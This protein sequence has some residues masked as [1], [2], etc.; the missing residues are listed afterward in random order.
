[1]D[2]VQAEDLTPITWENFNNAQ[3][4]KT[5]S[6]ETQMTYKGSS[7][8]NTVFED[9]IIFS[10][11]AS[12]TYGTSNGW[13]GLRIGVNANDQ[14]FVQ[15]DNY[16]ASGDNPSPYAASTFEL[17][18]LINKQIT[19]RIEMRNVT[20][21]TA[22]INVYVNGHAAGGTISITRAEGMGTLGT[23]VAF[24]VGNSNP[25]TIPEK[26]L[27]E[28]TWTDFNGAVYNKTYSGE[29][30]MTYKG[31]SLNHTAFEGDIIFSSGASMTYGTS[32]G[33]HGLR[34]GVNADDQLFVQAD[35][36]H[37]SGDNPSPYAAST[38]ELD[39]LINARITLRIEMRNVTADT[40]N[41]NVYVNG[42]AAG[43]TISI[44]RAEG[45]GT[46][47][48][49]VAFC[50]GNSNPV[51][52]PEKPLKEITW[53]DF[54]GAVYNKTYSGETQMTYKGTSL[55][56]TAFEGDIIFSSGAS[57]TYG[58]SN[59]WHGLRIGVNENDQL[60][61]QADNYFA[62]GNNP[63]PYA[64]STFELSTLTDTR[65]TLRIE[66]R[67]VTADTANINVYV[68]G[69][70]A[71]GTIS[72]TKAEGAGGIGNVL[73]FCVGNTKPVTIP[74]KALTEITWKD[75]TGTVYGET[76][77]SERQFQYKKDSLDNTAFEGDIVFS[78][79]SSLTYGTANG[80][81]GLRI[82]VNADDQ[83]FV[84]SDN[85]H[86]S[87]DNP[88]PYSA[89]V[90]EL[91]TLTDAR[92][93]LRVEMRN[94]TET[95][96]D[97]N[98][99]VN[100][101]PAGGRI[102]ITKAEGAG[103]IGNVLAFCV[104]DTKPVTILKDEAVPTG[105]T[106][107]SWE[108]F[109]FTG[110]QTYST[111]TERKAL[112]L[113]NLNDTLFDGDVQMNA[114]AQLVYGGTSASW[115]AGI[116]FLP[117]NDGTLTIKVERSTTQPAITTFNPKHYGL[118]NFATDRFNLKIAM[119]DGDYTNAAAY[120]SVVRIWV[121]GQILGDAFTFTSNGADSL[122]TTLHMSMTSIAITPYSS[123]T[124]APTG[125][126]EISFKDWKADI[127]VD[128]KMLN[129]EISEAHPKVNSFLGTTL[130]E[131][132]NLSGTETSATTHV[133]CY[134]GNGTNSWLGTRIQLSG[135]NMVIS[136][137]D[138]GISFTIDPQKAGV[139]N[140]FANTEF[141]WRIDTVQLGK[142]VLL[143]MSFNGV[144]YNK[145]PFV[146]Y[147]FADTISN[148]IEYN[149]YGGGTADQCANYYVVL[150]ASTKTLP[151]LY[152]DLT[153][154]VYTI[155]EYQ[156]VTFYEKNASGEWVAA[157]KPATLTTTGNYKLEFND[158]V[159]EYTQEI[160]CYYYQTDVSAATLVRSLK[161]NQ[162]SMTRYEEYGE[163]Y[164]T[165][166][167]DTNYDGKVDTNDIN[168]IRDMLLETYQAEENV[169]KISGF[170]SP[171]ASIIADKTYEIIKETGVN[172]IIE[173]D[174]YYS[175]DALE[176]YR[177]YQELTY[178]QKYGLTV[179]VKD[180][181]LDEIG[182]NGGTATVKTV[183]DAIVNYK[184]YQSFAGLFIYD[185]PKATDYPNVGIWK[186]HNEVGNYSSV[187]KAI[188][189]AGYEGWSNA[190]GGDADLLYDGRNSQAGCY[191]RYGYFN[192][193]NNMV[194]SYDLDFMSFTCYP[195]TVEGSGVK[196]NEEIELFFINL[197]MAK[198][199]ADDKSI[200]LRAFVQNTASNEAN[201]N[202]QFSE[203]QLKWQ[204][205]I[206]LAFGAKALEYFP[207][208]QASGLKTYEDGSCAS[209]V[210]DKDGNV[211]KFA[212]WT[213][214]AN[215]QAAAVDDILLH[216]TNVGFM[217]TGGASTDVAI[218]NIESVNMR[219]GWFASEEIT[220]NIVSQYEGASVA[221]S[222][223]E[224]GAFTGCF[225]IESGEY[226]G[227]NAMYIVNF[228]DKG[229]N[230]VTV[231]LGDTVTST[232]IYQGVEAEHTGTFDMT[233][234]AGEAVLVVY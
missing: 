211:T 68:N 160:A 125:L 64:A 41:V 158:G 20:A 111:H 165:R 137:L 104:G 192:Y 176:R 183:Q 115:A 220:N 56:H 9:D 156:A 136:C 212:E 42:H 109:G 79:G 3:Y 201:L 18:K 161:M 186:G 162:T 22:S 55:N 101:Y 81:H 206:N 57:M 24:C 10:S 210:V 234:A 77:T 49:V 108:E 233:L 58:T 74:E 86:A 11:G 190:F 71:G 171:T 180:K 151:V 121:N 175:N 48:T 95:T 185:E 182:A 110:G 82:G 204:A 90:F 124:T 169:M 223:A 127:E 140:S 166:L 188:A 92:I 231:T 102:S 145:A 194:D 16:H 91:S 187:A 222:N 33:W 132:V 230:T 30:Q 170:F 5:Y 228:S 149:S 122:G 52:I 76:Y 196:N 209:G 177:I 202:T 50:V 173:S 172:H 17:D 207:L 120:T 85:Y 135:K 27:K 89:S 216:A 155:P 51:T 37:A 146:L 226:A 224:Y 69:H 119:T 53:T 116:H 195:F 118:T 35:N 87:G 174:V 40:A 78:A 200:E 159:S 128:G 39:K 143:Y 150:G 65:I 181:R 168:D 225:E 63:S 106:P 62:S 141:S 134:G 100:G 73:A 60:F 114:G 130:N 164:E 61:V 199:V 12:M 221:S 6:G 13:H 99:Y 4:D 21:D 94:V 107:L 15:A 34:I 26:P 2:E 38:F 14:L 88:S 83:L 153:K 103:G 198:K 217:S 215:M 25:V 178:A 31:T 232:T 117:N 203:A 28:I 193:L 96:A 8:N 67:N 59:G 229:D 126:T 148:T 147:Q 214:N 205:N 44:T 163:G 154:G 70:A 144:L 197:A 32:N 219:T 142:N 129:G 47:G 184:D 23:V 75:F 72:I 189:L 112:H 29:T 93:T 131:I 7:L 1:M 213:K 123:R 105:L 191:M 97:I 218:G 208:V 45:M 133:I 157:T 152:H 46:L 179:T 227:K 43:G 19:L 54:N 113:E 80:W 98:V 138:T 36:Y 66:M 139:G 167:C 84:Q